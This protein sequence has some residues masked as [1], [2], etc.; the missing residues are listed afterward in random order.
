MSFA[1]PIA[2]PVASR[3]AFI[4]LYKDKPEWS[5]MLSVGDEYRLVKNGVFSLDGQDYAVS[6]DG[7]VIINRELFAVAEV[8]GGRMVPIS[9]ATLN[10]LKTIGE[11]F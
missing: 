4:K 7:R 8:V 10:E 1:A 11:V 3:D 9:A 6:K 2:S 5:G